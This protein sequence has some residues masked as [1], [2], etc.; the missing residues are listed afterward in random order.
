[1]PGRTVRLVKIDGRISYAIYANKTGESVMARIVAAR[2]Y[3]K[4][5]GQIMEVLHM[6]E[7]IAG[8]SSVRAMQTGFVR[9]RM[10]QGS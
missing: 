8:T 4:T 10:C 2:R 5:S 6:V 3:E 1:M 9:R 7:L